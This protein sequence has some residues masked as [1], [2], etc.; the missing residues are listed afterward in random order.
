MRVPVRSV[1]TEESVNECSP[2]CTAD[3]AWA[4]SSK[5]GNAFNA[6]LVSD[7][8]GQRIV[9]RPGK[10][11]LLS[12]LLI[13]SVPAGPLSALKKPPSYGY[14]VLRAYPHDPHSFTQGLI[15][16][17]GHLYESTGLNGQSSLR[18]V[19]LETGAVVQ[20]RDLPTNTFG[21]GL[22]NWGNTLLQLTWKA[23]IGFVYD[24]D[25][26]V[27]LRTFHYEGEGWGLT[28]DGSHLIL[29]DG[30]SSLRFL[31][32]QT[33]QEV[34]RIVVSDGGVEVHDLNELE[35]IR[36]QIYANVW[37]TDLIAI[38]SPKNGH[39][40]GWADLS[41]L[42]PPSVLANPD[43]VLNGIAFDSVRNRLFVTGKL[44]P[45]LFEIQLARHGLRKN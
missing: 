31:D 19:Q 21:E 35:Y 38:I 24:R 26:F 30:G 13:C 4:A 7:K 9:I 37:Q 8:F 5:G 40:L 44:W 10:S 36:G 34:K 29:S 14:R 2:V 23:H 27:L 42:R 1:H 45:K 33:F 18:E 41:G 22:T 32:P 28:Q 25:R 16:L 6:A 43:A 3:L 15:Y 17:D 11:Y 12:L 20:R 39:V